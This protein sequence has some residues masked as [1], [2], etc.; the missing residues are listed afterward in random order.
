MTG[1]KNKS[2][3][4]VTAKRLAF[5]GFAMTGLMI[6]LDH[7]GAFDVMGQRAP[8]RAA[9]QTE[10]TGP[11]ASDC[12]Y[13]QAP[14]NFRGL[15][16]RHRREV[17]QLTESLASRLTQDDVLLVPPQQMPRKNIIDDLIFNKMAA[18]GIQSA[19]VCTDEEFIRRAYL[20]LTGRIPS[21]EDVVNFLKDQNPI[22]RDILL[23]KLVYSQE[24]NDKWALFFGDL[25]KNTSQASNINRMITGREAFHKYILDSLAENKSYAQMATEIIIARGDSYDSGPVNF[26]VGGNVAMGPAQDTYDGLAVQTATIFLG[27]SS[28]DCLLCHDGAGHLDAVNL[29]GSK[30]TRAD[31][32]GMS[33]FFARTRR[34]QSTV[35]GTNMTR[36]NV[37]EAA[38]GEYDLNTNSGNRQNRTPIGN[39]RSVAPKYFL[40][41][42]GVSNTEDRRTALARY[43]TSDPQFARATVNYLWEELMVEAF[44]SPSNTF[45]LA[46]L[47]ANA[48]MPEGWAPQ[49][50]NPELLEALTQEFIGSGYN[51]RHIIKMIALSNTYQLSSKY[52]GTWKLDYVPYYARKYARRLDAEEIHDAIVKATNMPPVTNAGTV[53]GIAFPQM[54]GFPIVNEAGQKLRDIQWAMQLSDPVEPRLNGTSAAFLNSFL[55][56]NR[57]S[58]LRLADSSILQALNLMNNGFIQTRM[59]YA[60]G[61]INPIPNYNTERILSTVRRLVDT[62]GM[63]NAEIVAQL[64]LCTLSRN[65]TPREM[66]K[67]LTY[68]T[69][70][71]TQTVAQAKQAAI[72]DLQWVLLNK[73]DFTFNY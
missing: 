38:T 18:V 59:T 58:N 70:T 64:Y 56:G 68:F 65:P 35:A 39:L 22:K 71:G 53:N 7:F 42:G 73:V 17:S 49:P 46:R 61:I 26:I 19:P 41:G 8:R 33:A 32:W 63:T 54:I 51:L 31:A 6:A 30:V 20:D 47:K 15:Q 69:P 3:I 10:I 5:L 21:A 57:D 50:S 11:T 60:N 9:R 37:T 24:F 4:S 14:E 25:Y 34:T 72:E 48:Q 13:L 55:R 43:I 23:D 40:T 44:V 28:M 1:E 45:D 67:A 2:A 29:W 16:A 36:Y 52:P 27:L 12:D 62:P 66:A